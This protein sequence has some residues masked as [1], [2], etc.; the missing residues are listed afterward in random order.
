[1]KLE[2]F[3]LSNLK[4]G[5]RLF[6]AFGILSL[7]IL[8][9]AGIGWLGVKEAGSAVEEAVEQSHLLAEAKDLCISMD[10]LYLALWQMSA[11][12]SY[13]EREM[14]KTE[15]KRL[16][17]LNASRV[18]N[19]KAKEAQSSGK[20]F[21]ARAEAVLKGVEDVH[22][23]VM[24]FSG[25]G[26]EAQ[27]ILCK[28]GV[29]SMAEAAKWMKDMVA[30]RTNRLNQ[31]QLQAASIKKRVYMMIGAGALVALALSAALSFAIKRSVCHPLDAAVNIIGETSSGNLTASPSEKLLKRGDEV[32]TLARAV[33]Q[34]N[35]SLRGLVSGLS[36][37]IGT[38]GLSSSELLAASAN[39]SAAEE[40]VSEM[41]K[42]VSATAEATSAG[43]SSAAV[44][45]QQA[46]DSLSA[47]SISTEEMSATISE[48]ASNTARAK[49]IGDSAVAQSRAISLLMGELGTAAKQ[50]GKVTETISGISAQTNLLALNASIEAARAGA[51]GKG[52]AVVANEIKEL[53]RQTASATE[54]IKAKIGGVQER[55]G[56]AVEKIAVVANVIAEVGQ[57]ISSIAAAIEEQAAVTKDVA[58]NIAQAS[59]GVGDT[60]KLVAKSA[61]DAKRIA[62]DISS[63]ND[64]LEGLRQGGRQVKASA[65]DLAKLAEELRGQ[66]K[67]FKA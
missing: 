63:V 58:G 29:A 27:E 19:L 50:I 4:I 45:M 30:W 61:E 53:A 42:Q 56:D 55:T 28:D 32:G 6:L 8:A 36:K 57:I 26:P 41:A 51:A 18:K 54:D 1:M 2:R 40:S 44:K 3:R 38:L 66:A 17:D 48:V 24:V 64:A 15:L 34:M 67:G 7:F 11:S 22:S 5:Q 37:G 62:T 52:F 47:V 59:A 12:S 46:F 49:L 9:L 10:E 39:S 65:E 13:T 31:A 23:K 60:S 25:S 43:A 16:F 20:S 35:G 14:L 21:G 33:H